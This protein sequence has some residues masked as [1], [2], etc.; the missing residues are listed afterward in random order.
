MEEFDRALREL[1]EAYDEIDRAYEVMLEAAGKI[2]V[3]LK[4]VEE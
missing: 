4:G 2:R 1:R 3:I